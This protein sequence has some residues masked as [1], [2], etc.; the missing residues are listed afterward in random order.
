M[1]NR[2]YSQANG[3]L[4]ELPIKPST[5]FNEGDLLKWDL[6][7]GALVPL[8]GATD[9]STLA[10][11]FMTKEVTAADADYADARSVS[12]FVPRDRYVE[13]VMEYTGTLPT[14]AGTEYELAA[15]GANVV[16]FGLSVI[17]AVRFLHSIGDPLDKTAVFYV[18]FEGQY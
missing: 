5:L 1:L 3:R 18:R 12:V 15:G 17:P 14:L 10:V 7:A 11:A 8:V 13:F 9:A 2:T 4:K 6:A 16:N